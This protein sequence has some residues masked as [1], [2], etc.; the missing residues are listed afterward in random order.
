MRLSGSW[1]ILMAISHR[2]LQ[3]LSLC[4]LRARRAKV[5]VGREMEKATSQIDGSHTT[6][7]A[8]TMVARLQPRAQGNRARMVNQSAAFIRCSRVFFRRVPFQEVSG[9]MR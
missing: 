5:V 2:V 8:K 7:G 9:A 3:N 1:T 6:E 4:V